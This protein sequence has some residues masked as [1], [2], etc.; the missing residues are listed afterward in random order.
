MKLLALALIALVAALHVYIGWF[1]I[2]AWTSR[3]PEVFT[4][5]P[6][7]LFAQTL[8]MAANQ[9]VYNVFLAVGLLWSLFIRDQKW[10][11]HVASCFLLFVIAAGTFAAATVD[12]KPG[13]LQAV[14]AALAL[15]L[16]HL[17]AQPNRG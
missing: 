6:H 2:F 15:A 9:G 4:T 5:F 13:L 12:L 3:G 17:S 8:D 11:K 10:Q 16:L 1:E 14:P 7:E